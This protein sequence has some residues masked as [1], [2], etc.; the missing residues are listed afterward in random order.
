MKEDNNNKGN[1]HKDVG[2][3]FD[4]NLWE[5]YRFCYIT[6]RSVLMLY[7]FVSWATET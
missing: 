5:F 7:S 4:T 1:N 2:N 6:L 3:L